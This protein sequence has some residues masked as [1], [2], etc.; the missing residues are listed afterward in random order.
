MV[1]LIGE[2]NG[3]RVVEIARSW[4]GTRYHH[5]AHKKG[6]G[7]DCIGLIIGV[8]EELFNGRVPS[9]F[10]LPVYTPH[11]GDETGEFNVMAEY[12]RKYLLPL[13]LVW[14]SDG[15]VNALRAGDVIL[16]RMLRHGAT[17]HAGI[18]SSPTTMVHAYY[19]H[20]VMETPL[21]QKAGSLLTYAFRYPEDWE[22]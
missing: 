2:A 22:E 13:P 14:H 15:P 19:G 21:I 7:C 5:Q 12:S 18:L 11:W 10:S 20:D 9:S 16:W 8:W 6:V 17:K 3:D 4:I 1:Q